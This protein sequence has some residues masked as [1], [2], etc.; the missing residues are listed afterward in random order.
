[1][2]KLLAL[3]V[4]PAI[5]AALVPASSHAVPPC[6]PNPS[7]PGGA[8]DIREVLIFQRS[9]TPQHIP[10]VH[11][12]SDW[13]SFVNVDLIAHTATDA[14]CV[15]DDAATPCAFDITVTPLAQGTQQ[16]QQGGQI[17][18]VGAPN[19]F[20]IGKT[21]HYLCRVH[22]EMTGSFTVVR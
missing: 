10:D 1:M 16:W 4:A 18:V 13:L 22:S 2:R 20:E 8:H 11:Y 7:C 9:Y 3:V 12:G 14:R 5:V 15:D 17:V 19:P 21:Y 6:F